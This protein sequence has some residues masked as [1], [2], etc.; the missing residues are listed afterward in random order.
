MLTSPLDL[1]ED[2]API[3]TYQPGSCERWLVLHYQEGPMPSSGG[4]R[5]IPSEKEASPTAGPAHS[6]VPYRAWGRET[7]V[8]VCL[9][10]CVSCP[11]CVV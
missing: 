8:S 3:P 1:G 9:W 5:N 6:L 2:A 4:C 11:P 7:S 10:P